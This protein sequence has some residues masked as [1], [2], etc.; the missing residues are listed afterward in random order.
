MRSYIEAP[1]P[2]MIGYS[3]KNIIEQH[4]PTQSDSIYA[5][6]DTNFVVNSENLVPF[7]EKVMKKIRSNLK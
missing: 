4:Q 7:P 2:F 5:Y 3:Q 6:L 1:V